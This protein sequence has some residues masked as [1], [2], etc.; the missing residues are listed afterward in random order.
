[1]PHCSANRPVAAPLAE[2]EAA[3]D[4]EQ[5]PS[6]AV[7]RWDDSEDRWDSEDEDERGH[8]LIQPESMDGDETAHV[9]MVGD[10]IVADANFAD[11]DWDEDDE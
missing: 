10:G 8:G 9:V 1:M 3:A 5:P 4:A 6:P 2:E 7:D 11:D